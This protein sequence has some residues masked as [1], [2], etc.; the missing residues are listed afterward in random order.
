MMYLPSIVMVGY[1]FDKNRAFATGIAVCGSGIGTFVFAPLATYLVQEYA[2]QGCNIIISGIIFHG[3]I[4]GLTFRPLRRKGAAN[5]PRSNIIEQIKRQKQRNRTVSGCS[6][7]DGA[8]ITDDN[9]VVLTHVLNKVCETEGEPEAKDQAN[10]KVNTQSDLNHRPPNH[11][12]SRGSVKIGSRVSIHGGADVVHAFDRLD[13]LYPG[14]LK[15]LREYKLAGSHAEYVQS[16]LTVHEEEEEVEEISKWKAF[17]KKALEIFDFTLLKSVTFVVL[18]ASG[19]LV[20]TG[21]LSLCLSRR[22]QS[23]TGF[24]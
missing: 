19:V 9:Q 11:V 10:G 1:Y 21:E 6:M 5:I 17:Q 16:V 22:I 12:G 23:W 7:H 14:S 24:L 18:C 3:I 20:F 8:V 4:F 13:A 15:N 2:W